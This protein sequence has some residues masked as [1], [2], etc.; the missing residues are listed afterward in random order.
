MESFVVRIYRRPTTP[1]E[2]LV[3]VV[4][5]VGE[6]RTCVFHGLQELEAILADVTPGKPG[7]DTDTK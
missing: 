2:P 6:A 3:G 1:N 5:V 4:E 7:N